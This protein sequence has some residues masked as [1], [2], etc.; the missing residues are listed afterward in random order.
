LGYQANQTAEFGGLIQFDPGTSR[1]LTGATA[2]MSDW[3]LASTYGSTDP[4]WFHPITLNL[5]DVANIAGTPQPGSLIAS[6]TQTFFIPWRPEASADCGP[7]GGWKA[8]DS[9]CYSGLAFEV[10][11]NL[12]N[13]TV[14]DQL[15]YGIAYNTQSWGSQPIGQDG[16]YNSLNFGLNTGGPTAGSNPL[17]DTAYWN[18]RTAAYYTD[19]GAGGVGTFRQD[20]GWTP[21]SG[22]VDFA[23]PEPGTAGL[24]L[25][26]GLMILAG[27][28]RRALP[29]RK[30]LVRRA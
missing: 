16:P 18:T 1:S 28:I 24:M 20:T 13:V 9:N 25:G 21:Y 7:G 5:Y 23:T 30:P 22:A 4:G 29:S 3:A 26:G 2:V 10:S 15:I 12:N 14:P 6:F 19:G 27:S 8:A 17:P 11:F